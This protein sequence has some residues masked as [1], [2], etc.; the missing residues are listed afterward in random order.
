MGD[1]SK[2]QLSAWFE[3]LFHMFESSVRGMHRMKHIASNDEVTVTALEPLVAWILFDVK[4]LE[5][6]VR[7]PRLELLGGFLE[8]T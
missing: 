5:V 2:S 7:G 8:E 1:F 6:H 4:L 3:E